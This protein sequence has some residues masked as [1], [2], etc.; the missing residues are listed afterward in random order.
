[1]IGSANA[2]T[3][4]LVSMPITGGFTTSYPVPEFSKSI[5]VIGPKNIWLSEIGERIWTPLIKIPMSFTGESCFDPTNKF[6]D[7]GIF[8]KILSESIF[9]VACLFNTNLWT[10][11]VIPVGV[12]WTVLAVPICELEL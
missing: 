2:E 12:I 5:E 11:V 4:E 7:K 1:M 9:L 6:W 10:S 3:P 8:L